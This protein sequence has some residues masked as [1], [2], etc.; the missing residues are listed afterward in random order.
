MT[1]G[2]Q[3]VAG[4]VA[5]VTG[6]ASGLGRATAALLQKRGAR[7]VLCDL[8]GAALEKTARD[9]SNGSGGSRR[10]PPLAETV[11]VTNGDDVGRFAARVA[12]EVGAPELL[13]NAA[14]VLVV[15]R[16]LDTPADDWAHVI[17]VNLKGPANVCRAFLPSMLERGR[18]GYVV[19]VASASAFVTP[20]E[21]CAYGA[22]KHALVGLSQGLKDE[23]HVHG[24]GVSV[25]CP[26]FVNTPIL[27]RAR[28]RGDDAEELRRSAAALLRVRLSPE[29]VA[30]RIVRAAERGHS[31]VPVGLE[32]H[33]LW[34]L[35]RLSPV[36]A[37]RVF[38]LIRRIGSR[39]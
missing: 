10:V 26:G 34:L 28:I 23:L 27:E 6:A 32:A 11:D 38:G 29:R 8:D 35:A 15:G 21:L 9:L 36:G 16:F 31:F 37:A 13:V 7:L 17:D 14:G 1:H 22:T 5:L 39:T 18:G 33:A 2:L 19:N 24:I 3:S 30:E 12:R 4:R 20:R 25:V